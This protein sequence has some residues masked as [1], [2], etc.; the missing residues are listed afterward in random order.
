M[1]LTQEEW[2]KR[3]KETA[4]CVIID[5]RTIEEFEE[6]HIP[7]AQLL[8]IRNP[9]EFMIG[10]QTLDVKQTYF[11]YCRSG[12]RSAQACQILKQS[13][14][15]NCFNLLGGIMEWQGETTN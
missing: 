10:L 6:K 11:V 5:V 14:F 3:Q 2:T 1:D 7:S 4:G 12:A 13:G 8:D 9:Q 15:L